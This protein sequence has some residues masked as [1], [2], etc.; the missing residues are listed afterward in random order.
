MRKADMRAALC[1]GLGGATRRFLIRAL[2]IAV[3]FS[4]LI[5]TS[6]EAHSQGEDGE[7][8]KIIETQ[9]SVSGKVS[10]IFPGF[11]A[12]TNKKAGEKGS[13]YEIPFHLNDKV[14]VTRKRTLGEIGRGDTVKIRFVEKSKVVEETKADGTKEEKL[15]ILEREAREIVFIKPKTSA[16]TS[17]Y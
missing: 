6:V 12:V 3:L 16:L 15:Y 14:K 8:E 2:M 9:K 1:E 11:I 13:E 17:E 10:V 4:A 5:F 7:E